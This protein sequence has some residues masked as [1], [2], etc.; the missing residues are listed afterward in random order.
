MSAAHKK[1]FKLKVTAIVLLSVIIAVGG[2][3]GVSRIQ[4]SVLKDQNIYGY[5]T[6]NEWSDA[7]AFDAGDYYSLTVKDGE[8]L[9]VLMLTDTHFNNGGWYANYLW[10]GEALNKAVYGDI[11]KL[12]K[13]TNPDFIYITGDLHTASMSD[14]VYTE[15]CKFMAD[16]K[17][18]WTLTMGNHDAEH[19]ADKAKIAEILTAAEYC[20][21]DIGFT[22]LNGLGNTVIPIK[23]GGGRIIYAFVLMDFGDWQLRKNPDK[24]YSTYDAGVT[25]MQLYWYEWVI[26]G[27][28]A[29]AGKPVETM[30]LAHIPFHAVTYAAKLVQ[31]GKTLSADDKY[32]NGSDP[33][34]TE[35]E[36]GYVTAEYALFREAYKAAGDKGY[37]I[38]TVE[39]YYEYKAN[40]AFFKLIT[41]LDSTKYV[42]SGHNHCDGYTVRFDG[43]TYT[44]V[45]KTGDIYVSRDWDNGNRGGTIF[46]FKN[47]GG[48][49][50]ITNERLYV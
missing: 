17:I 34:D 41:D 13:Q 49:L 44:S 30:L 31:A 33:F 20:V 2:V 23:D 11:K 1:F 39:G 43:I 42:V 48:V 18:P 4:L 9:E 19:R 38:L 24:Q 32:I 15:F 47:N 25:D 40:D 12:I 45:V 29:A 37:D 28:T 7:L 21:Y 46:A 10:F 14:I 3:Y 26:N 8:T 50:D 27:L 6:P 35:S 5:V 16:F 22:N 36:F